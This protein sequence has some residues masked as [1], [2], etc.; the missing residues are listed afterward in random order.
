MIPSSST[1]LCDMK[2][3]F[4]DTLA[5]TLFNLENA[6]V[7]ASSKEDD[8]GRV[9]EPMEWSQ[10]NSWANRF[11][12]IVATNELGYL[13]KQGVA[14]LIAGEYD[15]AE[16]QQFLQEFIN[17]NQDGDDDNRVD[18]TM[19]SFTTCPFCR[20]AKDY[21]DETGI[22]YRSLE[23]DELPDNRGNELRASLG[24][25]TRRTSVPAIFVRGQFVGGCN[26][27]P[28]LLPLAESGKLQEMLLQ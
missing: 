3:P 18:V 27:G 22:S 12:E 2:R 14:D 20:R 9:G 10:S 15:R 4:L 28:G 17:N 6:R 23:L 24:R 21:L 7:Q 25:L 8:Q 19:L 5:S 13:F 16:T 1:T 26:D 11:S